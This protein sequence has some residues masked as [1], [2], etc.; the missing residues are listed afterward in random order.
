MLNV[1]G[2]CASGK[3]LRKPKVWSERWFKESSREELMR[4]RNVL[5][6]ALLEYEE[7]AELCV[8]IHEELLP[9]IEAALY[10]K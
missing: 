8:R 6:D 1:T 10:T 3:C 7:D 2:V 4:I 5:E 9:R